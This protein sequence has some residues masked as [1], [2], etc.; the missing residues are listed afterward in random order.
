MA[1]HT[2][3]HCRPGRARPQSTEQTGRR[4][5]HNRTKSKPEPGRIFINIDEPAFHKP[6]EDSR[7]PRNP[8]A[9]STRQQQTPQSSFMNA[10]RSVD[11]WLRYPSESGNSDPAMATP[12]RAPTPPVP[13]TTTA[14]GGRQQ[15]PPQ[16]SSMSATRSV[17]QRYSYMRYVSPELN[18]YLSE[19]S[20]SDLVVA[21]PRRAPDPRARGPRHSPQSYSH[22]SMRARP[23]RPV[24]REQ[25]P[26]PIAE[27]QRTRTA[28]SQRRPRSAPQPPWMG[29]ESEPE[30]M[31]TFLSPP[32][33]I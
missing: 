22:E 26:R 4:K 20:D 15:R 14:D 11:Q 19:S 18:D 12:R 7:V 1:D 23:P 30:L 24:T 10:T 28:A 21:T 27:P 31:R 3:S 16:S 2:N 29:E 17:G 6:G 5:Q 25:S 8:T 33:L 13:G 9:D 32:R